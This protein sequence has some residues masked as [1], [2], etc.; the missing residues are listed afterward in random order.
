MLT[1]KCEQICKKIKK[2]IFLYEKIR[3]FVSYKMV[4]IIFRCDASFSFYQLIYINILS[5]LL[6]QCEKSLSEILFDSGTLLSALKIFKS[7][8]VYGPDLPSLNLFKPDCLRWDLLPRWAEEYF[9]D[10]LGARYV[11]LKLSLAKS[12][13]KNLNLEFF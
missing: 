3:D 5:Q 7:R 4:F 12:F 11:F 1:C 10:G 8:C 9:R 6:W 13:S 2:K